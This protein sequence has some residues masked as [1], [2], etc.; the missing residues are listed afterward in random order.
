MPQAEQLRIAPALALQD[1]WKL[2]AEATVSV[3]RTTRWNGAAGPHQPVITIVHEGY[4][5][6]VVRV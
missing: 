4:L 3:P 2:D 1:V 5:S 6:L